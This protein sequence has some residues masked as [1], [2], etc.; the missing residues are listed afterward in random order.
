MRPG[1]KSVS[2]LLSH[3]WRHPRRRLEVDGNICCSIFQIGSLVFSPFFGSGEIS[4]SV[5]RWLSVTALTAGR[6]GSSE[7]GCW[8]GGCGSTVLL[9]LRRWEATDLDPRRHGDVPGRR[10]TEACAS[11]RAAGLFIDSQSHVLDENPV[12]DAFSDLALVEAR[13]LFR[14]SSWRLWSWA[15]A[16]RYGGCRKL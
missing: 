4:F 9:R 5:C 1:N 13:R 12:D 11:L 15:V 6:G 10:G 14:R 3:R 7:R 8:F 16:A 2:T